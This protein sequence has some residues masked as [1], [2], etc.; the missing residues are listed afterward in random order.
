MTYIRVKRISKYKY[1]YLVESVSSPKGPR[2]KVKKYLGKVYD[3][4][5][6][7]RDSVSGKSRKEFVRELIRDVLREFN[8]S[9]IK[10]DYDS[11]SFAKK[12]S[13]KDVVLKVNDGFL[14]EFTVNLILKFRKSGDLQKDGYKLAKYFLD[15]GLPVSQEEFVEF[16]QL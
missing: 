11:F 7:S 15:A 3:V 6:V 2:Q 12:S 4:G 9:E 8:S 14:C 16:Y 5:E 13:R 1:A 10:V